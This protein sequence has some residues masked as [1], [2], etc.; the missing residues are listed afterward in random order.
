MNRVTI[1][2][3]IELSEPKT[4]FQRIKQF[5]QNWKNVIFISMLAMTLKVIAEQLAMAVIRYFYF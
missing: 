5:S 3:I 2:R 4:K 1:D